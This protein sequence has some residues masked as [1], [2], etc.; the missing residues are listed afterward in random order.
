MQISTWLLFAAACFALCALPGHN[1]RQVLDRS[2]E[3]G[4][5]C[6]R[7][8][9]LGCLLGAALLLVLAVLLL[10]AVLWLAPS[11]LASLRV[12]GVAWLAFAC[13]RGWRRHEA[14]LDVG[15]AA[16]W[17][18]PA[19]T[20]RFLEG[21][22]AGASSPRLLL[23][24]LAFLPQFIDAGS[25]LQLQWQLLVHAVTFVAVAALCN[26]AYALFAVRGGDKAVRAHWRL[27]LQR[28][29]SV[30]IVLLAASALA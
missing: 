5:H 25:G 15:D 3:L 4:L 22:L 19:R 10:G 17:L 9:R 1:L 28:A 6:S 23:L 13:V 14:V 2:S 18:R 12:A 24:L 16:G 27:P 7:A 26:L 21:V 11:A 8:A 29:S 30:A 20:L